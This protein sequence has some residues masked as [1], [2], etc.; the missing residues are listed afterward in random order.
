M[1]K[2]L[3]SIS[4]QAMVVLGIWIAAFWVFMSFFFVDGH[5]LFG[6][7]WNHHRISRLRCLENRR[8]CFL[9][10]KV[11]IYKT[12]KLRSKV[13]MNPIFRENSVT[14]KCGKN[15]NEIESSEP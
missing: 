2:L 8:S 1:V 5:Q 12:A 14:K 6:E 3:L 7:I 11:T 15:Q 10:N 4:V 9:R 13:R